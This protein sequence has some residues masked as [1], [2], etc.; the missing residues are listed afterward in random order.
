MSK[1][2]QRPWTDEDMGYI[3]STL[4]DPASTVAE[5][6]GRSVR[7][8][9]NKRSHIKA[10]WSRK[11]DSWTPLEDDMLL[12]L[13]SKLTASEI[14]ERMPGRTVSSIFNRCHRLGAALGMGQSKNPFFISN[15]PLI[16]KTCNTCGLLLPSKWFGYSTKNRAWS[17]DC[18]NCCTTYARGRK[19]QTIK[20]ASYATRAQALSL[21][22]ALNSG[23]PWVESDHRVLLDPT[24]THLAKAL[25]L[26]RTYNA[27]AGACQRNGY[28]SHVGIGDPEQDQWLIDNPNAGHVEEIA[29]SL[30]QAGSTTA[31]RPEFEW[32]D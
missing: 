17:S 6:I 1:K 8:V 3:A 23:N 22:N 30:N 11:Y 29:A 4:S 28:K 5:R 31:A 19:Y 13:S 15:R 10:G 18:R 14:A 20:D 9:Y 25:K 32:D 26:N 7:M 16:A 27:I 21:P 24:L 12:D 2:E